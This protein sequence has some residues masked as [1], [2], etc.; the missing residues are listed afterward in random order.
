M[1]EKTIVLIEENVEVVIIPQTI[2][3][4]LVQVNELC[5]KIE[6]NGGECPPHTISRKIQLIK[7][8]RIALQI[9]DPEGP[10]GLRECKIFIEAHFNC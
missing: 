8:L 6:V 4:S 3:N 1:S 10:N 9:A 5:R 7:A 2:I